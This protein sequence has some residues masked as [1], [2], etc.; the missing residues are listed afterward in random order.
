MDGP[1]RYVIARG[2]LPDYAWFIQQAD[3]GRITSELRIPLEDWHAR[4]EPQALRVI[5]EED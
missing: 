5:I 4:G 3:D 2:Y 1:G